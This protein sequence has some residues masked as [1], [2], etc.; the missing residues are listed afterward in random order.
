ML[1]IRL[2]GEKMKDRSSAQRHIA[3]RMDFPDDYGNNLDA[4]WEAL[5]DIDETV[6]VTLYDTTLML[7]QLGQYG[8]D[9]LDTFEDAAAANSNIMFESIQ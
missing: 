6:A 4:L 1:D 7:N 3:K 5:N 8:H 2:E 9:L